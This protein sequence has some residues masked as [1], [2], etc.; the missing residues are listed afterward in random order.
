MA[1][2]YVLITQRRVSSRDKEAAVH[3]QATALLTWTG[4]GAGW[5][6]PCW[7]CCCPVGVAEGWGWGVCGCRVALGC[8]Y[9]WAREPVETKAKGKGMYTI[10][11]CWWPIPAQSQSFTECFHNHYN[12]THATGILCIHLHQADWKIDIRALLNKVSINS[13]V[14]ALHIT[15]TLS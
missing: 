2:S 7:L 12:L 15:S 9:C 4:L 11:T 1:V 8:A 3:A 13:H 5:F 6:P 10:D 14:T